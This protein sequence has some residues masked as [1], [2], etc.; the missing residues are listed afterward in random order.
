M[1]HMQIK[2]E[3]ATAT[4]TPEDDP[5]EKTQHLLVIDFQQRPTKSEKALRPCE[6][7]NKEEVN[8]GR[9]HFLW[10]L[11]DRIRDSMGQLGG[12]WFLDV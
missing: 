12:G 3:L 2:I 7:G 5:R 8:N 1:R 11:W 6:L 9:L 10:L 4:I